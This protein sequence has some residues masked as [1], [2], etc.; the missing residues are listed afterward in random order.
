MMLED[1]HPSELNLL[2]QYRRTVK[3]ANTT[4]RLKNN[5]WYKDALE[6]DVQVHCYM[7]DEGG[8]DCFLHVRSTN[9]YAAIGSL[10]PR[11]LE[12]YEELEKFVNH[13]LSLDDCGRAKS[14]GVIIY[15]ADEMSI[16]SLGPEHQNPADLGELRGLMAES[17]KEVLEDKTVS[18]ESH[19]WRLFPYAGAAAGN[20]FATAVAV[21][22]RREDTL[23]AFREIG[24][25]MNLPIRTAALCAPLCAVASLP[26]FSSADQNGTVAVVS[27]QKFTLLA[28]FNANFDLMLLRYMPHANGAAV[29]ANIGP[30]VLATAAAFELENPGIQL[31]PVG[32]QDV[33][34]AI[35]SLQS[36]MMASEIV[37]VDIKG[38]VASKHLPEGT[39]LEVLATTQDLDAEVYP[40]AANETFGSYKED[41]WHRQD[42]LAPAREEIELHPAEQDMKLLKLGRRLKTVAAV[43]LAAVVLYSGFSVWR[44]MTSPAWMYQP[45]NTVTTA[46]VLGKQ[47]QQFNHWENLLKDR[48]KAWASMELLTQMVPEDG[49][50][51]LSDVSHRVVQK[52]E[53]GAQKVG[54]QKEW[55]VN[56]L[57]NEK[58]LEHLNRLS[59]REG[60]KKLFSDV[61]TTTGNSAY[62]PDVGKRDITVT[63]KQLNNH[64]FNAVNPKNPGDKLKF[65][66]KMTITQTFGSAD[67]M[68]I[69]GLKPAEVKKR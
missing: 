68:A 32:G 58:G 59:T 64:K 56:G 27:Y 42:F 36:S 49:S 53:K 50:V 22:R 10:N 31:L 13:V 26:W 38:I 43:L 12:Q 5:D 51:I 62:L 19:A 8:A 48:S 21:S 45:K 25:Q 34:A 46:A 16:A 29:P 6:L 9:H 23:R 41:G 20:E 28:F 4:S 7:K 63:M 40:L 67:D 14:L 15:I 54:L 30:A 35:V 18:L 17:P 47:I 44:K 24:E 69:A 66:F 3:L 1:T 52:P 57:M 2:Q 11:Q 33:E 37:L 65:A 60:I 55:V 61:A 39:P